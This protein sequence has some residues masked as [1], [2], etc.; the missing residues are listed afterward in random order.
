MDGT[1]NV[2][3]GIACIS[4]DERR[5]RKLVLINGIA[6]ILNLITVAWQ[7]LTLGDDAGV[8]L[9][10]SSLIAI[11]FAGAFLCAR[12]RFH[13]VAA[14]RL[15]LYLMATVV[16]G[17]IAMSGGITGYFSHALV[18]F[19]VMCAF[20][21]GAK[22]TLVFTAYNA[23]L[24]GLL[25]LFNAELPPFQLD[26]ETLFLASCLGIVC[27]MASM[28]I[29]AV[30]LVRD[31]EQTDAALQELLE[32]HAYLARHDTL[33]GLL[34]RAAIAEHLGALDLDK[35]RVHVFMI[36]LDGFKQVN[37]QLGH[38][39]GDEVIMMVADKLRT[40]ARHARFLARLG[41]DE[42]LVAMDERELGEQ[43]VQA[44]GERLA[45]VLALSF[46]IDGRRLPVSGSVGSAT[47]PDD[48]ATQ[49]TLLTRADAALYAA[50]HGGKATF[51]RF[52]PTM[53][54]PSV[55]TGGELVSYGLAAP[56]SCA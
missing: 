20:L 52:E 2:T 50:K 3:G 30:F 4:L 37:D 23:V 16:T 28:C 5:R 21:F 10:A 25:I 40:F 19:P 42:F 27:T 15:S 9:V 18:A 31:A 39:V 17:E 26:A 33:T 55:T 43:G 1:G 34:N 47:F 45:K 14:G 49:N 22:D 53:S 46:V 48:G 38:A 44:F 29:G 24:L 32:R 6:F 41:G 7:T 11:V 51:R 12:F 8:T 56:R 13:H 54:W 36:D 35:D